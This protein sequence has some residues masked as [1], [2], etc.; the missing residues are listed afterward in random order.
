M[1]VTPLVIRV[2]RPI[3]RGRQRR[4][5]LFG[6]LSTVA[7]LTK[8]VSTSVPGDCWRALATA[9]SRSFGDHGRAGLGGELEELKRFARVAPAHEIDDHSRLAGADPGKSR[10]GV[11]DHSRSFFS[12]LPSCVRRVLTGFPFAR[13][14][15]LLGAA[16]SRSRPR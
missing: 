11:T 9:L 2:A 5:C 14:P 16:G 15:R 10:A 12:G 4:M 6:P 3:A 13:S 1:W 8:S 7:L